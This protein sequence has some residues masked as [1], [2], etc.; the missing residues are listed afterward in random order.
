VASAKTEFEHYKKDPMFMA[1]LAAYVAAGDQKNDRTIRLSHRSPELHRLFVHFAVQF[2]GISRQ[3]IH[4]WLLLYEGTS[5]EK[6]M[7]KWSKISSVPLSQFYKNQF[8]HQSTRQTLHLGVGN[9]I[10][11]STYHKQKL[12]AWITLAERTW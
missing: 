8:L 4:L 1:G 9:T 10:I 2:L 7:K 6:A 11:G 12:K 3:K 5:E